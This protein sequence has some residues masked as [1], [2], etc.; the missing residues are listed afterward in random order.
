MGATLLMLKESEVWWKI[1]EIGERSGYR[2]G[3]CFELRELYN[4]KIEPYLSSLCNKVDPESVYLYPIRNPDGIMHDSYIDFPDMTLEEADTARIMLCVI[5]ALEAE[6]EEARKSTSAQVPST[7]QPKPRY[8]RD[9]LGRRGT[10][11]TEQPSEYL[12]SL[13]PDM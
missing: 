13:T 5:L 11:P 1:A 4:N 12:A 2:R 9:G 8:D 6:E 7:E 3:I 10:R